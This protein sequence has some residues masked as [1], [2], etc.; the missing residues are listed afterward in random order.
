MTSQES[1]LVAQL[2]KKVQDLFFG[3]KLISFIFLLVASLGAIYGAF[4]IPHFQ[5]I[6]YDALPGNALPAVTL[7]V[8]W[9]QKFLIITSFVFPLI[10]ILALFLRSIRLSIA[11]L[12][13]ALGLALIQTSVVVS[14]LNSPLQGLI[15]DMSG[16]SK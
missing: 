6:Y 12:A 7:A 10:G 2:C 15:E 14:A 13:V 1:E 3:L 5:R 4:S 16:D 9:A 8:I 11:L